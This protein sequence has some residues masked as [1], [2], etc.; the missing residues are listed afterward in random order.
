MEVGDGAA[1]FASEKKE[2]VGWS[3]GR[4]D[5]TLTAYVTRRILHNFCTA[6][7]TNRKRFSLKSR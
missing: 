1:F 2:N 4:R 3:F 7:G 5:R 6:G